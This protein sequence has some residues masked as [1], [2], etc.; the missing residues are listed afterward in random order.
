MEHGL[1]F[2]EVLT[3]G[4]VYGEEA[5]DS[6][7]VSVASA[8]SL[9]VSFGEGAADSPVVSVASALRWVTLP[10]LAFWQEFALAI[11]CRFLCI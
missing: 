6:P 3:E 11:A 4:S 7:V 10:N 8:D 1:A 5:A 2:C 9:V